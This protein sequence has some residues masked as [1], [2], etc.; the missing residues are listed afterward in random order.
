MLVHPNFDPVL[1]KIGPLSVHWYG[2][3]YLLGFL[4]AFALGLYRKNRLGW[5]KD[6]LS[7]LLFYCALG[8]ILGGRLGYVLLYKPLFYL[9]NPLQIVMVQ[10]G[11][12]SFHGGFIGVA[13]AIWWFAR[14][15][16]ISFW[17]VTDF[18]APLATVGLFFGRI[19]NFINQE[20][21]GKPT[22]LPWGMLFT[23]GGPLPRH[24]SMLYEA[25]LEGLVLFLILWWYSSKPRPLGAV[26]G[27]FLIGYG[28][29]RF[30]VEFVREPDTHIGYVVLNWV[31]IGQLYSLP[32]ILLGGYLLVKRI[33]KEQ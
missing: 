32:M 5:S 7:D 2:V 11:G 22:D 21:W 24:P 10:D 15:K 12:M 4:L 17:Q 1:V 31:T 6:D 9:S 14:K 33:S 26:T 28:I 25:L 8:V 18:V 27:L 30:L 13:L 29:F 20:L 23:N 19:G 16:Q 3:M